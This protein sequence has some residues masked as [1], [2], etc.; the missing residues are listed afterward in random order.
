MPPC[1]YLRDWYECGKSTLTD[2][3]SSPPYLPTPVSPFHAEPLQN[4]RFF[5]GFTSSLPFRYSVIFIVRLKKSQTT[6]PLLGL[7]SFL[8]LSF[9][10]CGCGKAMSFDDFFRK[11]RHDPLRAQ[12]AGR[13]RF[14]DRVRELDGQIEGVKRRVFNFGGTRFP[15]RVFADL[16]VRFAHCQ[17]GERVLGVLA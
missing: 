1:L 5:A 10:D 16:A 4:V 13:L 8:Y 15:P 6:P 14:E 11:D 9:R 3:M 7:S 12:R 17:V 2:Q